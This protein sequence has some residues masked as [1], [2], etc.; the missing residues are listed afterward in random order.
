MNPAHGIDCACVQC[1]PPKPNTVGLRRMERAAYVNS[2]VAALHAEG[3]S[4]ASIRERLG[5]SADTVR[6]AITRAGK[7][8]RG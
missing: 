7:E 2:R 1:V 4:R 8:R 3:V 6:V 5:V